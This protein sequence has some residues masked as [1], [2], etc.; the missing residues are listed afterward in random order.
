MEEDNQTMTSPHHVFDH[1][2]KR[3]NGEIQKLAMTL[4]FSLF[5]EDSDWSFF[6]FG[7]APT[8]V[9]IEWDI[10]ANVRSHVH[11]MRSS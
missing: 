2:N 10:V 1:D 8:P 4:H 3:R 11:L 6:A 9:R 7:G 5:L